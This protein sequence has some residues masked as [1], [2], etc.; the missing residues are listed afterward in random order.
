MK[1]RAAAAR[2]GRP[3]PGD[4][5]IPLLEWYRDNARD[6][7]WRH[8]ADPYR[9]LLSEVM[10]Q[11][12]RVAAVI[13]YYRRFLA[14][15]PTVADLAG[16][17][18]DALLK[19]WQGLGYYN[20]ARNLQKA[21]RALMTEHGGAFPDTYEGLLTLP[22]VGEYTAGAVASIA[23]G[24]SEAAVDGNVLR[25]VTRLTADPSDITKQETK[26]R[27]AAQLKAVMPK[28]AP[29]RFNQALMELGAT[30]CLPNGAPQCDR[31]PA[32]KWCLARETAD[33]SFPKKPPKKAK[34]VEK[35]PVW[36][37]FGP[38]KKVAL[39]RRPDRGLLAGLYEYPADIGEIEYKSEEYV[40]EAVHLFTHREW[41]M[42]AW[43]AEALTDALPEG[44]VWAGLEEWRHTYSIPSAFSAFAPYVEDR[45]LGKRG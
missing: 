26:R 30:V 8:T 44:W 27:V 28:A 39:R 36:L 5:V 37:L 17:E 19:L 25:V 1:E 12:T 38:G 21:A 42:S 41:H 23:F 35:R 18:E 16:L 7:P 34:T 10:L 15:A 13:G 32:E 2:G 4:V 33:F 6:L 14:A 24:R 11:Q 9:I 45:L 22:G 40:G 43:S 29:G 3:F 31:C 20:R